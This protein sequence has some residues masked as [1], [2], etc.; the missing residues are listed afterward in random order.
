VKLSPG[1]EIYIQDG[2]NQIAGYGV[3]RHCTAQPDGYFV[4][5]ELAEPTRQTVPP[6]SE[7]VSDYYEFLQISRR[8][9]PA[10]IQRIHRFLA[11]RFH[12]DNPETGDPE[13]FLLLDRAYSVLSDPARRAEYDATLQMGP[14]PLPAFES[15]DFMDGIEGETNRRLAVLSLLYK[16]CRENVEDPRVTLAEMETMMGFPREYLD[17]TTWYLRSKKYI[18]RQDNSDFSL[19]VLGVD[20]VEANY[21]KIPMLRRLLNSGVGKQRMPQRR[22]GS[23]KEGEVFL[24]GACEEPVEPED[25]ER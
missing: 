12:P 5:I 7:G 6:Q 23:R 16:R 2:E 25:L 24:L 13:K 22:E 9:E 17:F 8:A 19:T 14:R 3:V 15:V 1:T 11:A 20:Y 18:L 10:T 4:G 21:D